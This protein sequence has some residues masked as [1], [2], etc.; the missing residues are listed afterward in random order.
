V[1]AV[2]KKSGKVGKLVLNFN[3]GMQGAKLEDARAKVGEALE[4]Y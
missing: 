4:N 3:R 1:S 2:D